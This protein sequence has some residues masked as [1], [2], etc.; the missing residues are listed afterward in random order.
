[1]GRHWGRIGR[2]PPNYLQAVDCLEPL[3]DAIAAFSFERQEA[4]ELGFE[5]GARL[6]IFDDKVS[7]HVL[8]VCSRTDP[9]PVSIPPPPPPRSLHPVPLCRT[10][11]QRGSFGG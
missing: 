9:G 2:L 6:T 7:W 3:Y 10:T 11:H 5:A 4:T 8:A 1:M